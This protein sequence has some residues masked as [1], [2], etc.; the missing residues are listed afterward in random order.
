MKKTINKKIYNTESDT[1]LGFKYDG[2]FG[3]IDGFEEQ[4]FVTKSNQHYIYGVGGCESPYNEPTIK[5]LT[6]DETIA[7]KKENNIV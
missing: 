6:D 2:N 7:W 1:H 3:D 5:L 4:L